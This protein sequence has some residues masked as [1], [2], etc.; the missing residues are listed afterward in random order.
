MAES[1]VC[2]FRKVW[3]IF[4][5]EKIRRKGPGVESGFSGEAQGGLKLN[6]TREDEGNDR[7]KKKEK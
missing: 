6:N 3:R 5:R 1:R 7:G 2:A 4:G